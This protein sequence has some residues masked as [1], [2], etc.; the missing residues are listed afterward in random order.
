VS[1]AFPRFETG[2]IVGPY[3]VVRRIT[4]ADRGDLYL[5]QD[6]EGALLLLRMVTPEVAS[7]TGR[8]RLVR[9]A[10]ALASVDHPGIARVHGVGEHDGIPWIA[11]EQV[12]GVDLRQLVGE[13]GAIPAVLAIKYAIQVAEALAAAHDAGVF[14]RDLT[15][16]NV[17]LA[18]DGRI[19]LVDF[20]IAPRRSELLDSG[21]DG[22]TRDATFATP[23]AAPE[24]I[25]HGLADERSDVWALG[26]VLYELV[27]GAPPFGKGGAGTTASIL[28]D[29]PSFPAHVASGVRHAVTACLR[30]SA[31]ARVSS[32]RHLLAL[33]RE[34][35]DS[36]RDEPGPSERP[37]PVRSISARPSSRASRPPPA[38][39]SQPNAPRV[40]S[41]RPPAMSNGRPSTAPPSSGPASASRIA[42]SRGRIKGTAIRAVVTWFAHTYGDAAM[43]LV[44]GRASPE[45]RAILRPGDPAAGIMA[46]GWYDTER[47]GELLDGL[48]SVAAPTD[49]GE[50][51]SRVGEAL[52]RDNVHGVYR[53]LFRLIASPTLIEANAQRVWQ[54]YVDEGTL[55][56]RLSGQRG[57]EARVRGWSKHHPTVCRT[58]PPAI[59]HVLRAVG[60][61]GVSVARTRC[62][63]RGDGVC[64]FE[65]RLEP[66][67]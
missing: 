39:A 35:L 60:Y 27:V 10:R 18:T 20:G 24:Q 40:S 54:T 14:H 34:A 50:F 58:I 49:P 11:T 65:T 8:A 61:K 29:E 57:F 38:P 3:V 33:L 41:S 31:F 36:A 6:R 43:A 16:A 7:V 28:R 47:V 15:P 30:K 12:P 59:E 21:E 52:A 48:E 32:P 2:T 62:V 5:A 37:D 23:Y 66:S 55:T 17:V 22:V 56:V 42:T 26:C 9:D 46:S 67:E 1:L 13:R 45:L 63:A 19:V 51:C 44:V 4:R 64:E 53:A 25:E